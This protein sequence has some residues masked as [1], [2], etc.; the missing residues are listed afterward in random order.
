[1]YASGMRTVAVSAV[2]SLALVALVINR[3]GAEQAAAP[4]APVAAA[5]VTAAPAT[6]PRAFSLD[7]VDLAARQLP[8]LHSVIVSR[9]GELL[10]EGYYNGIRR[11]R[12]ANIKSASKSVI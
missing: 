7:D 6:P 12:P 8:R 3:S 4:A 10:F 5:S 1:M 9:R 11:E 2:V